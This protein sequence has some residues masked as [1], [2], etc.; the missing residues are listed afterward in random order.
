[1][2]GHRPAIGDLLTTWHLDPAVAAISI[3]ALVLYGIGVARHNRR[4]PSRGWPVERTIAFTVGVLAVVT[5][6]CAG[7]DVYD[8]ELLSVHMAQHLILILIAAPLLVLGAPVTLALRTLP[9]TGRRALADVVTSR[10]ARFLTHPLVAWSLFI[11]VT[12]WTHLTGFYELTLTHPAVHAFEHV[13]YLATA[14][15]FW[16]PVLGVEPVAHRPGWLGRTL[17]LLVA[18]PAMGYVGVVLSIDDFVR[19]PAY[20]APAHALGVNALNDQHDAGALMWVVGSIVAAAWTVWASWSYL[21]QE[22]ARQVAR[23]AYQDGGRV[24]RAGR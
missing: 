6:L 4:A 7:F 8:D 1:M 5:A 12:L 10:P 2:T 19:Y 24:E 23:E 3:L 15:L 14:I 17:Y 9:D 11:G 22:E 16:L 13:L 20:L 21:V 18:M